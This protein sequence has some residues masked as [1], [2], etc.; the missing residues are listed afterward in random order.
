MT[1]TWL[2]AKRYLVAS[3]KRPNNVHMVDLE[4]YDGYG[5]CSCEYWTYQLGPKLKAGK[6]PLKQCRHLRAVKTL[7][8]EDDD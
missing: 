3:L 4:E 8:R 1:I 6:K 2:E 7:I 5:E